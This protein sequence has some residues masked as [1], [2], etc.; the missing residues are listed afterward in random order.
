MSASGPQQIFS[1]QAGLRLPSPAYPTTRNPLRRSPGM[2]GRRSH[3]RR[4]RGAEHRRLRR[5]MPAGACAW[6]RARRRQHRMCCRRPRLRREAQ[7]IPIR[8]MRIG[9][10]RWATSLLGYFSALRRR[11][12][13]NSVAG[14]Q[15][16]GQDARSHAKSRSLTRR[17]SESLAPKR[18]GEKAGKPRRWIDQLRCCRALPLKARGN[19][20]L[21]EGPLSRVERR[22]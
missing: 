6:M 12:G 4:L 18:G 14:P 7:G 3:P 17:G 20:G 19:E 16:E 21:T 1:F 13:A 15:G 10:P 22:V 5:K 9:T 2:D 8:T 11:S